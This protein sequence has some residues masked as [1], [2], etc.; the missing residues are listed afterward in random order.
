MAIQ[1]AGVQVRGRRR[2]VQ[3]GR[4]IRSAHCFPGAQHQRHRRKLHRP[5]IDVNA[6]QVVDKDAVGL[7][8]LNDDGLALLQV[9]GDAAAHGLQP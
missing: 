8:L 4:G 5:R 2:Q 3:G 6:V 1:R 9:A 7:H